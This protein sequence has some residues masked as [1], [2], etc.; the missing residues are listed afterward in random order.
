MPGLIIGTTFARLT[1]IAAAETRCSKSGKRKCRSLCRC[2]CGKETITDNTSL[3]SG[4]TTSCG[5]WKREMGRL[6]GR[7]NLGRKFPGRKLTEDHKKKIFTAAR[8]KN[9]SIALTGHKHSEDTKRKIGLTSRGRRWSLEARKAVGEKRR[10]ANHP[11]WK[12]GITPDNHLIRNSW[13]FKEW[14]QSVFQRDDYTCQQCH[15]RGNGELH[16]HHLLPF[17]S[18]KS[19]RFDVAN[20]QTLCKPC[21][22]EIHSGIRKA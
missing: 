16:A 14:R 11:N 10:G 1:V 20:G 13:E 9:L 6:N 2:Q 21:H 19:G 3:I 8:A 15:K 5:C 4:H 7:R 17:A 18:F 12:G 22:K